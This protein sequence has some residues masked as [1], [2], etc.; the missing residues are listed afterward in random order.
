MG[1]RQWHGPTDTPSLTLTVENGV[2]E[3]LMTPCL[4]ESAL[5]NAKFKKYGLY[6]RVINIAAKI[7]KPLQQHWIQKRKKQHL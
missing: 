5:Y 7:L 1:A 3:L 4:C 2:D 6:S